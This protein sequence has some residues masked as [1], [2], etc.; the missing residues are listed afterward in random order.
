MKMRI[1][2]EPENK[3]STIEIEFF[4][5][6]EKNI[7]VHWETG[8]RW[9]VFYAEPSDEQMEELNLHNSEFDRTGEYEEFEVSALDEFEMDH[10]W[11]GCWS[12]IRVFGVNLTDEQQEEIKEEIESSEDCWLWLETNGYVVQDCETYIVGKIDIEPSKE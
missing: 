7:W 9:G 1:K 6:E 2:L 8:W 3:K 12:D 11:D 5:N 10:T 4:Q